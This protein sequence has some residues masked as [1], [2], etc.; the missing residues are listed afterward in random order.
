[1][2]LHVTQ[3]LSYDTQI[4]ICRLGKTTKGRFY[5][6][7]I[8]ERNFLITLQIFISYEYLPI[9]FLIRFVAILVHFN[10]ILNQN[11]NI[12]LKTFIFNQIP[13]KNLIKNQKTKFFIRA[14]CKM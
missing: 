13:K 4:Y 11:N 12:I 7:N 3:T 1:M 14:C 5:Y 8:K 2:T 6:P 10:S 9:C